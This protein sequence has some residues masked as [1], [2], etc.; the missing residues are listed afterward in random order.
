MPLISARP[1]YCAISGRFLNASVTATSRP[2]RGG[3]ISDGVTGV[4]GRDHSVDMR[5]GKSSVFNVVLG[6]GH[7]LLSAV[8]GLFK[9]RYLCIC[10]PRSR[11]VQA[12]LGRPAVYCS[13]SARGP[14][15]AYRSAPG[16][17]LSAK[18]R[19]Q[20][21]CSTLEMTVIAVADVANRISRRSSLR[22]RLIG[23]LR[24]CCDFARAAGRRTRSESSRE[25][26]IDR[27]FVV[28]VLVRDELKDH[29]VRPAKS[30]RQIQ[31]GRDRC[32]T[33]FALPCRLNAP[34]M[35]DAVG[36]VRLSRTSAS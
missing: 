7:G 33:A 21:D 35:V 3:S 23:G 19:S 27:A 12:R 26:R 6:T 28:L 18:T 2:I 30:G 1:S 22:S 9:G 24:Q 14:A 5:S 29:V 32:K 36:V 11:P 4:S 8:D 34:P 10:R 31:T 17:F 20:Y 13:P 15:G 16:R 25:L